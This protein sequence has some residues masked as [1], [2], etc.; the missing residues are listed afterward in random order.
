MAWPEIKRQGIEP[1]EDLVGIEFAGSHEAVVFA[2]LAGKADVGT[3]RSGI[4]ERL[5][6]K[7]GIDLSQL[8]ILSHQGPGHQE[9]RA[10]PLKHS[11]SHYPE[12]PLASL[13]HVN[14]ELAGQVVKAMLEIKASDTPALA[15]KVS[16]WTP[17][18][19]YLSVH[20]LM[21]D[22][23][24]AQYQRYG[25]VGLLDAVRQHWHWVVAALSVLLLLSLFAFYVLRLNLRIGSMNQVLKVEND[26]NSCTGGVT[27]R[28][29]ESQQ[30]PR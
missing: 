18:V 12:W 28:D 6:N 7:G 14:R 3:V 25:E 16:H 10:F 5:A 11:T 24:M 30:N 1:F 15:A 8:R 2:V 17:S 19:T 9:S 26:N 29:R 23:R 27:S 13:A 20:Q 22:L 21:Q 4:L